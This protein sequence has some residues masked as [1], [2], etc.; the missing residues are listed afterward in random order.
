MISRRPRHLGR[1]SGS[2]TTATNTPGR[3]NGHDIDEKSHTEATR[4]PGTDGG[5][6]HMERDTSTKSVG[7][8]TA[9]G[10]T[11]GTPRALHRHSGDLRPQPRH[12]IRKRWSQHTATDDQPDTP[13]PWHGWRMMEPPPFRN[14]Q[15]PPS[16]LH[17]HSWQ[18]GMISGRGGQ[19]TAT[20]DQPEASAPCQRIRGQ[21]RPRIGA[22]GADGHGIDGKSHRRPHAT[23]P[24][25]YGGL[26]VFPA[27]G[28]PGPY[29]RSNAELW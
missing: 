24:A 10:M 13:T 25:G 16:G 15:R 23:P 29:S 12:D 22:A 26:G 1:V 11:S 5:R 21:P 6:S 17:R 20:D 9:S 4:R 18:L 27:S 2:H 14:D 28:P 7:A 19:H 8:A 3:V